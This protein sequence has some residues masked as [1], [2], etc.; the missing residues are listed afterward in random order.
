VK[1]LTFGI[2]N[3]RQ[4]MKELTDMLDLEL[5]GFDLQLPVTTKTAGQEGIYT[6]ACFEQEELSLYQKMRH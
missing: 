6:I 4:D 5:Y 2:A 1:K 3:D